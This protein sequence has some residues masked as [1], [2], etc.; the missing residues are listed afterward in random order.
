MVQRKQTKGRK[1]EES[2]SL[3]HSKNRAQP[4]GHDPS[5]AYD[6]DIALQAGDSLESQAVLLANTRSDEQRARLLTHLQQTHGNAYVQ[7]LIESPVVQAKLTVSSP[8]DVYEKEADRVA[9]T[10][11]RQ[12][13]EEEIQPKLASDI[14]RQVEEEEE[15]VQTKTAGDQ[16]Q[17]VSE[18]LESQ[19][20]EARGSGQTLEETVRKPLEFRL[21]HDFSQ[22]RVHT[23]SRADSLSRQLGAEAF[24]TSRDVFFREGNYQPQSK[25][26]KGLIAHELTHVVQQQ[27]A[28]P[29]VQRDETAQAPTTAT[30]ES[31]TEGTQAVEENGLVLWT[32]EV[33]IPI[34]RAHTVLAGDGPAGERAAQAVEDVGAARDAVRERIIPLYP[35][36]TN[37]DIAQ[38]LTWVDGALQTAMVGLRAQA[39]QAYSIDDIRGLIDPSSSSWS[40][41]LS[42]LASSPSGA[43][44]SSTAT[45]EQHP[46]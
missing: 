19:I 40:E 28:Q 9:E 10:L 22:V 3:K 32:N 17:M 8:G 2:P 39:G 25:D 46:A 41:I 4:P 30:T 11:Q 1:P 34:T 18:G 43:T 12:E 24:T 27:A 31:T 35:A 44:E 36:S 20:E 26:G 5:K 16:L 13:E 33:V 14:Q 38:K 42:A 15:P 23:D 37:A 29:L 21:G 7:R 6:D 45:T